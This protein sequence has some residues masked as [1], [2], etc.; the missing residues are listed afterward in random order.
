[1][2]LQD[3]LSA[4]QSRGLGLAAISYDPPATLKAFADQHGITFPL[5]SD[6]GSAT[7]KAYGLL[8]RTATG[9]TAGIP[10]PG[11]FVLDPRGTVVSR[12]FEENYQER[13]SATG[14]LA[15]RDT[16]PVNGVRSETA[17]LTCR[18]S[19][20]DG[21]V[22]PGTRFTLLID[23]APRKGVHVYAPGQADYIPVSLKVEPD[24]AIKVHAPRFPP[25]ERF[26]FKPLNETQL[27]YSK[28]FRILQDVTVALTPAVRERARAAGAS[29]MIKAVMNYQAC[30]DAICYMPVD[31]PLSWTLSLRP[32]ER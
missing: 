7:I 30:D 26:L 27:V 4:I 18:T 25:A 23:V 2:Q 15:S 13:A 3:E 22:A 21:V 29:L 5:L 10:Y 17:H 11:T 14:L 32:L 8:N 31:V 28:P 16:G 9:R 1:V 19:A 12:S 24:A 6:T 20:S